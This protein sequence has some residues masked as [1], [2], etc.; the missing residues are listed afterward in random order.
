M[1]SKEISHQNFNAH[2]RLKNCNLKPRNQLYY[3]DNCSNCISWCNSGSIIVEKGRKLLLYTELLCNFLLKSFTY[4]S[5]HHHCCNLYNI[6]HWVHTHSKSHFEYHN[7]PLA[8]AIIPLYY[9]LCFWNC[10]SIFCKQKRN[11]EIVFSFG[12][13]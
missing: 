8:N 9:S 2:L 13:H 3:S 1:L 12:N 6:R 4:C 10:F 7:F 5:T 11:D